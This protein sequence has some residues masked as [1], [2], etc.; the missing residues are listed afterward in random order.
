MDSVLSQPTVPRPETKPGG[1]RLAAKTGAASK[2]VSHQPKGATTVSI[3]EI[4][5]NDH[6]ALERGLARSGGFPWVETLT[7]GKGELR[8]TRAARGEIDTCSRHA[9]SEKL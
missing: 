1:W 2:Y 8:N 9:N 6:L 3:V 5:N 4:P 7:N